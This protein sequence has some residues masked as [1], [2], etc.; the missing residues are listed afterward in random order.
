MSKASKKAKAIAKVGVVHVLATRNNTIVSITDI[1][2]N[3]LVWGSAGK[4]EKGARK[5]TAHAGEEAAHAAT[6]RAK[7]RGMV[8][9]SVIV[10][11]VGNGR[12][13]AVRGVVKSG[14]KIVS[15]TDITRDQHAGCRRRKKRRG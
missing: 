5:A 3:V 9:V 14:L 8:E 4:V 10:N 15:I 7:E 6:V 2:G 12:D 13:S 11:G 1:R